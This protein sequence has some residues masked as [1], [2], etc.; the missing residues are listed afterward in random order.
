MKLVSQTL[1]VSKKRMASAPALRKR[2][3]HPVNES[4]QEDDRSKALEMRDKVSPII[5]TV[6]LDW[7]ELIGKEAL[8]LLPDKEDPA[9]EEELTKWRRVAVEQLQALLNAHIDKSIFK[10]Q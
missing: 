4:P 2:M 3:L 6:S 5:E 8:E 7:K 1:F 10:G 9:L